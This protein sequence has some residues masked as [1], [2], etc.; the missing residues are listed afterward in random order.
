[1]GF[2]KASKVCS[3]VRADELIDLPELHWR[4]PSADEYKT[5]ARNNIVDI[6]APTPSR[7]DRD[8]IGILRHH[9]LWTSTITH[10]FNDGFKVI[11]VFSTWNKQIGEGYNRGESHQ[12]RCV[13]SLK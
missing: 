2:E 4:L 1:M 10:S 13:V 11:S 7:P 6:L 3:D 12:V 9:R 5:A 8:D